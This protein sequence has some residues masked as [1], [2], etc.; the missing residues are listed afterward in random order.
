MLRIISL[1]IVL[2]PFAQAIEF[3]L[4]SPVLSNDYYQPQTS[5]VRL[6]QALFFDKL[7]S[8]NRNI[9]CA[10]CHH[11]LMFSGDALSLSVGEGGTGLGPARIPGDTFNG[12]HERVPRNSPTLFNVGAKEYQTFFHDGRVEVLDQNGNLRTPAGEDL[13]LNLTN[14]LAAQALFPPTSPAEM[15]GQNNENSHSA[16]AEAGDLPGVWSSIASRIRAIPAY[17]SLFEITYGVQA[18]DITMAHVANAVAAFETVAFRSDTSPF[19][20]YL[21]G[22]ESALNDQQVQGMELFYGKAQ[23]AQCH[24]GAF[25]TDHGFHSIA[26]PPI[27]P[28]KGDGFEN[29]D[30]FGRSRVSGLQAD[31]YRFRTPSLRNTTHTGPWGHNGAYNSLRAV[32]EHHLD[33]RKALEN[34]RMGQAILPYRNDLF[35]IDGRALS[36]LTT[37]ERILNSSDLPSVSL[38]RIEVDAILAFLQALTDNNLTEL[39]NWVPSRVPSGLPIGD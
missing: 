27:G 28:G 26:L 2:G 39:R 5:E 15:A 20:A 38:N 37:R 31:T 8:G 35:L 18:S 13:P 22:D 23:C 16:M 25:Q 4:P 17:T 6:G 9:S 24:S 19:D 30:D 10:S 3:E 21:R 11:P 34:Y 33:P 32:V 29:H 36:D 7:L 12:I 14:V 1:F